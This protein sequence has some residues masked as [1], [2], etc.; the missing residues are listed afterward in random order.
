MGSHFVAGPS[1]RMTGKLIVCI[2]FCVF[3]L[4]LTATL[5]SAPTDVC[6][7]RTE[8]CDARGTDYDVFILS[9]EML[10]DTEEC[11][12]QCFAE[13]DKKKKPC[14]AFTLR[15]VRGHAECQILRAPCA[16]NDWDGCIALGACTSGPSH[17]E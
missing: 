12:N 3:G 15:T 14:L 4:S 1:L 7:F 9:N 6:T 17:C 8:Y 2:F 10:D 5:K 16:K 13:K 11:F